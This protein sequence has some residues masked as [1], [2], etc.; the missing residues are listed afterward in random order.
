MRLSV[1][2]GSLGCELDGAAGKFFEPG[3]ERERHG[4][5]LKGSGPEQ[6]QA[7]LFDTRMGLLQRRNPGPVNA[8]FNVDLSAFVISTKRQL[9]MR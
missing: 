7:L 8:D 3:N 6:E 2:L 1:R 9:P 5:P 4:K